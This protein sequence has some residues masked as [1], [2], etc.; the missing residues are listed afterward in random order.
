MDSSIKVLP[1]ILSADFACLRDEV[2]AV[3]A[4][5]AD[6]IHCDVMD[7]HFVPNI[8]FGPL[9]VAAVKKVVTIPLDVH[10]MIVDPG[11][12]IDQFCKAG[13]D[14]LTVHL[15]ISHDVAALCRRIRASGV[16]AG[17]SLNPDTDLKALLPLLPYCDQVLLMTV[18]PGFGGQAFIE[19][20]VEKIR[21][22]RSVILENNYSIDI[23]VDGGINEQTA[24]M[25]VRS[26]A[27]MLVAGSFIFGK[28][29]Y[30][31]QIALLK[32]AG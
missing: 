31:R 32:N 27:N 12:F 19:S 9:V 16:R 20:V 8:T 10:L 7:G 1:S 28:P 5:K 25:C 2:L 18:F 14:T 17:I 3:Q 13:A 6:A 30:A 23:E 11:V 21:I 24:A 29:D 4:A 22:L 15:E 26:G